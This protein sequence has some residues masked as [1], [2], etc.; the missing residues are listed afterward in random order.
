MGTNNC[1]ARRLSWVFSK[2]AV[3]RLNCHSN[4]LQV[5]SLLP[6]LQYGNNPLYRKF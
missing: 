5:G 3:K 6:F 1:E 4:N 2:G